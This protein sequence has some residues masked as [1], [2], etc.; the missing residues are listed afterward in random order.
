MSY[1]LDAHVVAK[2]GSYLPLVLTGGL[3]TDL[4]T[5]T[6]TARFSRGGVLG[7]V[8]TLPVTVY[9]Y[10]ERIVLVDLTGVEP[11]DI[12]LEVVV[13]VAGREYHYPDD[14]SLIVTVLA[15]PGFV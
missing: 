6:V 5:G 15:F 2:S 9:S 8:E 11:G 13:T 12:E 1:S 10:D 7:P 3:L 4:T 14:Q